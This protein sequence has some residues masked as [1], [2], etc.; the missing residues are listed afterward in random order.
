MTKTRKQ[1]PRRKARTW[2][3]YML[4]TPDN[5]L[6]LVAVVRQET[7]TALLRDFDIPGVQVIRVTVTEVLS[8]PRTTKAAIERAEELDR[9]T[10]QYIR[11]HGV[12]AATARPLAERE[13]IEELKAANPAPEKSR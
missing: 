3:R 1:P 10:A 11:E 4:T 9:R 12:E 2:T 6:S 8:H 7:A 13:Y 5:L